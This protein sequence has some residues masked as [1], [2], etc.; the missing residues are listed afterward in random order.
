MKVNADGFTLFTFFKGEIQ[1][2][3]ILLQVSKPIFPDSRMFHRFY[4][5]GCAKFRRIWLNF[6][7]LLI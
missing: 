7:I 1:R 3:V 2:N 6:D 5:L 4:G